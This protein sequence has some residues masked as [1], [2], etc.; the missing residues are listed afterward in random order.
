MWTKVFVY[1]EDLKK[2]D[3]FLG[4]VL[5]PVGPLLEKPGVVVEDWFNLG[6]LTG[7]VN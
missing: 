4:Y 6:N 5:L 1:D 3:D 2:Q 7:Q